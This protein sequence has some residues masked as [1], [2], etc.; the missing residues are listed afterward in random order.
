LAFENDANR[1]LQFSSLSSELVVRDE[2]VRE[3]LYMCNQIFD[4]QKHF[5]CVAQLDENWM[6]WNFHKKKSNEDNDIMSHVPKF[7]NVHHV[8]V[9]NFPGKSILKV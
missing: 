8:V 9:K 7:L 6:V 3:C 4:Q 2:L 5:H 1:Q